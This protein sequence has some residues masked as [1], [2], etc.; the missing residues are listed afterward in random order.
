MSD[1]PEGKR[2]R[3]KV[4]CEAHGGLKT[5]RDRRDP[6]DLL[7]ESNQGRLSQLVPIRH[8][9]ML[10]SPFAFYRGSAALMASDLAH[11]PY[12]GVKVQV[13]GDFCARVCA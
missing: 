6:I 12:T 10:E 7:I 4:P 8:R 1:A 9:Q 13:C 2:L 3:D 5:P 11:T